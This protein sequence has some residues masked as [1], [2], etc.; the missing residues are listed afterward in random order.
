LLLYWLAPSELRHRLSVCRP[1]WSGKRRPAGDDPKCGVEYELPKL[2][3]AVFD[4][5]FARPF[6]LGITSI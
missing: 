4:H 2:K 3:S 1:T 5:K 6:S